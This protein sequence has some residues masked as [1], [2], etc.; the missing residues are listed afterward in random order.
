MFVK[1]DKNENIN[2]LKTE[3]NISPQSTRIPYDTYDLD[4]YI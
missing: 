2:D 3:K 4:I 1:Q